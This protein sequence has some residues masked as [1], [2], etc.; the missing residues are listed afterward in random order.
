MQ[1]TDLVTAVRSALPRL[2]VAVD[3]D[4]TLAPL[5]DDPAASRPVDGAVEALTALGRKGARVAVVTGRDALTAVRLGG[6]EA[7]GGLVVEG[8]YGAESWRDG[9]LTT[10]DASPAIDEVRAALPAALAGADPAVWIED[11]RLSLVVHA[12]TAA[13]PAGALAAL[14]PAVTSLAAGAGL[15]VHP[16]RDVLEIRLPGLDKAGALRRL[17]RPGDVTLYLGD[18]LGDIPAFTE[19]ARLR[20]EGERAYG[21]AVLSSGVAAV[22]EVA[23]VAV[24]GPAEVVR[25]L[26]AIAG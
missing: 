14:T 15:D 4:G 24:D 21:V 18:D 10:P 13:D 11:K 7:V 9:S 22:A 25:L 5:V 20:A 3:F 12:R 2:L 26:K 16:G 17:A 19:I 8:L 23:D 6:F 1:L